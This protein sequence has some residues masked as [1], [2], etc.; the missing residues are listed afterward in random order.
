MKPRSWLALV[1]GVL[2]LAMAGREASSQGIAKTWILQ[3]AATTASTGTVAHV[4]GFTVA[5]VQIVVPTGASPAATVVFQTS[6]NNTHYTNVRCLPVS[7]NTA[8]VSVKFT[9]ANVGIADL[10][11]RCNVSGSYWFRT[12]LREFSGPG[13]VSVFG[14]MTSGDPQ[15]SSTG[16]TTIDTSTGPVPVVISPQGSPVPV[17]AHLNASTFPIPVLAHKAVGAF[18]VVDHVSSVQHVAAARPLP[19]V[20][21]PEGGIWPVAAH[22]ATTAFWTIDHISSVTHVASGPIPLRVVQAVEGTPWI[23]LSHQGGAPWTLSHISSVTHIAT[24]AAAPLH[25]AGGTGSNNLVCHTYVGFSQST[26]GIIAHGAAGQKI[27]ICAIIAGGSAS[28]N[29]SLVEGTGTTCGTNTRA[30]LGST[31]AANGIPIGSTTLSATAT[32]PFISTDV[33]GNAVCIF[34]SGGRVA[35]G[36]SYRSNQ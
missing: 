13:S 18:W 10:Q 16:G 29:F 21:S 1:L 33:A 28:S 4:A 30:M 9:P 26:D 35:G 34:V 20:Q 7:G 31:V 3:S 12:D 25:I 32:F 17:V 15:V 2:A 6:L 24:T 8:H 27:F 23:V 36:M 19:V 5:T 11:W 14:I 22:K